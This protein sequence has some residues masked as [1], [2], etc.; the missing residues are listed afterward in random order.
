[1]GCFPVISTDASTALLSIIAIV[2]TCLLA[3]STN[4]LPFYRPLD[5]EN[6]L[7]MATNTPPQ[8]SSSSSQS[9]SLSSSTKKKIDSLSWFASIATS[10][11][12]PLSE[13]QP[14]V[15]E[16]QQKLPQLRRTS[17]SSHSSSS[18]NSPNKWRK[19]KRI[20]KVPECTNQI[21]QGDVCIRHGARRK[22]CTYT[23]DGVGCTS[24]AHKGGVCTL[25]GAKKKRCISVGCTNQARRHGL[26]RHHGAYRQ[27][28][29]PIN[30]K[31]DG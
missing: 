1:V 22:L 18:S 24:Y 31:L 5:Y 8:S 27:E 19:Y 17:S 30:N 29:Q 12:S 10:P 25:H 4:N 15:G 21:V 6:K 16:R 23:K 14:D 7:S 13:A 9:S 28:Q 3:P 26:C 20:C 11:S 2:I